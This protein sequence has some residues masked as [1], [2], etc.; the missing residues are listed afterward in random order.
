GTGQPA[1]VV[2]FVTKKPLLDGFT[3]VQGQ[4]GSFEFFRTTIDTTGAIDKEG[5][6][7]YRLNAA[8]ENDNS[9]RDFGFDERTFAAPEFTY[10]LTAYASVTFAGSY[11]NDR[12]RFDSGIVTQGGKVGQV[13]INVYLNEP[14][15]DFNQYLDYK[16]AV[17]LNV[18]LNDCWAARIGGFVGW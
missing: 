5:R 4:Y 15:T 14:A 6:F 11:T 16:T 2:N 12:R 1:G 9:F 3:S 7:L 13:P 10:R 18:E 17:F 8:Y